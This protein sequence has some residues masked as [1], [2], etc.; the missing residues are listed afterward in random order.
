MQTLSPTELK[1]LR[2]TAEQLLAGAEFSV[3]NCVTVLQEAA[4][5]YH[6]GEQSFLAD[7]EY[8]TLEGQLRTE[9]PANT[10]FLG[11]GS[12]EHVQR[13]DGRH[14]D[15]VLRAGGSFRPGQHGTRYFA[16]DESAQMRQDSAQLAD[17]TAGTPLN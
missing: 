16:L 8:D 17:M 7:L 5:L 15:P 1:A 10:F 4:D 6:N 11:V 2:I 13:R 12:S 14:D 3:D 9:D